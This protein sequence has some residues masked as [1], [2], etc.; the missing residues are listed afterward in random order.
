MDGEIEFPVLTTNILIHGQ[1]ITIPK[2]QLDNDSQV[3]KKH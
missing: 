2:K 1:A 3:I